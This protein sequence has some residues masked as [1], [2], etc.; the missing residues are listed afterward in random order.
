MTPERRQSSGDPGGDPGGHG[1]HGVLLMIACCLP[2]VAI[3]VLIALEA[4]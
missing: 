1:A 3:F 4:I 2:M